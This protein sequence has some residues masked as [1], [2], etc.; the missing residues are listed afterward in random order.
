VDKQFS[1][2]ICRFGEDKA[3]DCGFA[4]TKVL[5]WPV[6]TCI[7]VCKHLDGLMGLYIYMSIHILRSIWCLHVFF[8]EGFAGVYSIYMM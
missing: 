5:H 3:V 1:E 6:D 7:F 4:S 2:E 8:V